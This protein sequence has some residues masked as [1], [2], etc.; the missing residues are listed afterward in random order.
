MPA[1]VSQHAHEPVHGTATT[2][3]GDS[4]RSGM[5][6]EGEGAPFRPDKGWT[7]SSN[8]PDAGAGRAGR[9]SS[10]AMSGSP[11]QPTRLRRTHR[12]VDSPHGIPRCPSGPPAWLLP[13]P[14]T[15]PT[16]TQ[17]ARRTPTRAVPAL[18]DP[19][20]R[21]AGGSDRTV[22]PTS[23][24]QMLGSRCSS[25]VWLRWFEAKCGNGWKFCFE[26]SESGGGGC[27]VARVVGAVASGGVCRVVMV[28]PG[29]A[30][31][32]S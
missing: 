32:V 20:P 7:G 2:P 31:G 8:R 16:L 23:R 19:F 12:V 26:R 5:G 1:Q 13:A 29:A 4:T 15:R 18:Q 27:V 25:W 6:V 30:G 9:L 17:E 14:G 3:G 28:V 22:T 10:G 24:R 21:G 11:G